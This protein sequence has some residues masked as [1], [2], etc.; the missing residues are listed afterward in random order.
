MQKKML[1]D[2]NEIEMSNLLYWDEL[3]E[4]NWVDY[5]IAH[6]FDLFSLYDRIVFMLDN[7]ILKVEGHNIMDFLERCL[8]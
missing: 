2:S 8:D 4:I 7:R 3:K 6:E 1:K 5:P